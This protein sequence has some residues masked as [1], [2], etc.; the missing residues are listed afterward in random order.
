MAGVRQGIVGENGDNC[1]WT[2][3]KKEEIIKYH[4]KWK[5][6]KQKIKAIT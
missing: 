1:T 4:D 5:K 3:I 2:T 6:I